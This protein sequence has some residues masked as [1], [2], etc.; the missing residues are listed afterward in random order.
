MTPTPPAND[1]DRNPCTRDVTTSPTNLN[2]DQRAQ[3][4]C[5]ELLLEAPSPCGRLT[6]GRRW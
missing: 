4:A 1:R 3:E 6:G 2:R 5:R